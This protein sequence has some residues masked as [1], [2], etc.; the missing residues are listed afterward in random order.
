MVP[1]STGTTCEAQAPGAWEALGPA[2][3]AVDRLFTP[4]SGALL[5]RGKEALLRSDDGGVSWRTIA[6]P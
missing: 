4:T 5:A 3:E 1:G 2:E 6:L